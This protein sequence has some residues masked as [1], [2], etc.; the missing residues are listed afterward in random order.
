[1]EN[2]KKPREFWIE[3]WNGGKWDTSTCRQYKLNERIE[4][5]HVVEMSA[6]TAALTRETDLLARMESIK[7]YEKCFDHPEHEIR[8]ILAVEMPHEI[9]EAIEANK[10]ARET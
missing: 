5:I 10:K 3:E 9:T 2:N 6:L 7:G 1:M 4:Q 8:H